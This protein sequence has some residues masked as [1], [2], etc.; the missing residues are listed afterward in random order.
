MT[1]AGIQVAVDKQVEVN[2]GGAWTV[3]GSG[4]ALGMVTVART[5]FGQ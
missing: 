1:N 4:V 3:P 5:G 2:Y